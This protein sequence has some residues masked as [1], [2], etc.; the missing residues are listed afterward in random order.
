[1]TALLHQVSLSAP[2][3]ILVLVGFAAMKLARW[4]RSVSEALSKFVF[5][6]ALPALLFQL[7]SDFSKLPPVASFIE[8]PPSLAPMPERKYP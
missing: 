5:T 7:L 2:L 3:F 4:P 1:M 6:I 8:P